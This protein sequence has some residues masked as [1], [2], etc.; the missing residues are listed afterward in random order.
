MGFESGFNPSR[1]PEAGESASEKL[2]ESCTEEV[3]ALLATL[4]SE[5]GS[6]EVNTAL[7]RLLSNPEARLNAGLVSPASKRLIEELKPLEERFNLGYVHDAI[8]SIHLR[9]ERDP[10]GMN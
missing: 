3:A 2:R 7:L 4:D 9:R 5:F 10:F 8:N 1:E 6:Q